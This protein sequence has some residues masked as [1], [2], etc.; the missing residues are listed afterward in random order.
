MSS[1][2]CFLGVN[3]VNRYRVVDTATL[4]GVGVRGELPLLKAGSLAALGIDRRDD[5]AQDW[6][7]TLVAP[8]QL[9][10]GGSRA[11]T[12]TTRSV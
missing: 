7:M 11:V 1:R 3:F 12:L 6:T 4:A 10:A 5:Q 8:S 9:S 2:Q